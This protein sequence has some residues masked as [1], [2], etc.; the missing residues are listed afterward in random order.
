MKHLK[1]LI[2]DDEWLIR[3]EI[4]RLLSDYPE[5]EVIGDVAYISD[6]IELIEK[7]EPDVIFLDIELSGETGFDLLK[8]TNINCDVIFVTAFDQYAIH[9]FDVNALDYLLKPFEAERFAK[10]IW[11]LLKHEPLKPVPKKKMTPDDFVYVV[12]DGALTY[13]KI[14]NL[15][16]VRAQGNY[17]NIIYDDGKK[18]LVA[19]TLTE[20]EEILP[21]KLFV[22]IH[23]S[24]IINCAYIDKIEKCDNRTQLVYMKCIEKPFQMSRRHASKLK[25]MVTVQASIRKS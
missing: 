16:S 1:A 20:W 21:D 12:I 23:R 9:A 3:S 6:A 19:K 10:A 15:R 11:R 5:I 24:A 14:S 17:T 18:E 2:V 4:I 13:L 7:Y 8:Q 22:R 25:K